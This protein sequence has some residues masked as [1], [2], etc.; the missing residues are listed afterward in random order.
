MHCANKS[1]ITA[2][3]VLDVKII[4]KSQ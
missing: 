2:V 4:N 1:T 3:E